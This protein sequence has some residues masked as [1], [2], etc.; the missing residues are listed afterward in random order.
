MQESR[1]YF[2]CSAS[3]LKLQKAKLVFMAGKGQDAPPRPP[4]GRPEGRRLPCS[5][6]QAQTK[7][8]H[9]SLPGSA[10]PGLAPSKLDQPK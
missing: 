2:A 7:L 4:Q 1:G 6:S 10:Y 9:H 8:A 5:P 3:H